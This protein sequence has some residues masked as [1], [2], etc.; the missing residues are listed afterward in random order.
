MDITQVVDFIMTCNP[1]EL[2][3]INDAFSDRL[4]Q[5]FA[6]PQDEVAPEEIEEGEEEAP[7]E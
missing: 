3:T 6:E 4:D 1:E 7:E 2:S 5:L